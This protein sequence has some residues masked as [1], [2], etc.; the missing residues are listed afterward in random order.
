MLF[1]HNV[2]ITNLVITTFTKTYLFKIK[3]TNIKIIYW[4]FLRECTNVPTFVY[5]N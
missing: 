4:I 5:N 1:S 2:G 3:L